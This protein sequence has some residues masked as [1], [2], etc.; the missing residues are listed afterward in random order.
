MT[1][2]DHLYGSL[3]KSFSFS[4]GCV[5]SLTGLASHMHTTIREPRNALPP[6]SEQASNHGD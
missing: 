1:R 5:I 4:R 6:M 2:I 3:S